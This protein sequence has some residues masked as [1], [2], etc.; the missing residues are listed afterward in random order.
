M[1]NQDRGNPK[2]IKRSYS[3]NIFFSLSP[4]LLDLETVLRR[5]LWEFCC[6]YWKGE[7]A[8]IYLKCEIE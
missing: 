6:E 5:I 4:L 7:Y 2:R 3:I 8:F 1:R